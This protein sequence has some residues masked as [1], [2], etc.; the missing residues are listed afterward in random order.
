MGMKRKHTERM[1][2]RSESSVSEYG[3]NKIVYVSGR[4]GCD[5]FLLNTNHSSRIL[6]RAPRYS[7]CLKYQCRGPHKNHCQ[8]SPAASLLHKETEESS[9]IQWTL[10]R[11]ALDSKN[12]T[13]V[14]EIYTTHCISKATGIVDNPTH[15]THTLST[16]L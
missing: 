6:S 4:T 3:Q 2:K 15:P 11:T 13:S 10:N 8:E 1:H 5:H 7:H 12:F 16:L 9:S 14:I